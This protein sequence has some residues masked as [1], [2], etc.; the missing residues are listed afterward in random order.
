MKKSTRSISLMVVLFCM[1]AMTEVYSEEE[2]FCYAPYG[3]PVE[4]EFQAETTLVTVKWIKAERGMEAYASWL[5][6]S[7]T[8]A[9][10]C[11]I[12]AR[13][14]DQVLGDPDMDSLGHELLHCLTGDFHQ[15]DE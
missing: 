5:Y 11:V 3:G 10:I 4:P 14:P 1:I 2:E 15:G 6:D 13:M 7:E 12:T 8:N 9:T